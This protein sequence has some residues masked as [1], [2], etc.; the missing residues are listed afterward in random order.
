MTMTTARTIPVAV[1][2]YL[3]RHHVIT[4]STPSFT[5]MPHADTVV[6]VNDES[7]IYFYVVDGTTLAR[8]IR[9]S[10]YVSFTIDDYLPDWHKLREL[11]G[12]G[13]GGVVEPIDAPMVHGL[14]CAK[15]G[16]RFV[17]PPGRL[18]RLTPIEMHFVH[19]EDAATGDG[20]V[21]T[22]PAQLP[23]DVGGATGL[24]ADVA[25]LRFAPGDVILPSID[26]AGQVFVVLEG[27]VEVRTKGFGADQTVTVV[28]AGQM[29]GDEAT[30]WHRGGVQTAHAVE[31]TVLLVVALD[32]VRD[33]VIGEGSR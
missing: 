14:I 32:T 5:G 23:H 31:S 26:R 2:D 29:F 20:G 7:C 4:V 21:R 33:V 22:L 8:N 25:R 10:R 6:Y 17:P 28:R 13:R 15:F 12:V 18:H 24:V 11:Q 3:G 27:L 1:V 30:P 16:T 9:D 19:Y